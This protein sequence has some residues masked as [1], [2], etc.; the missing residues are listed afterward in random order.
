M[1]KNFLGVGWK[2]PVYFADNGFFDI[3]LNMGVIGL[4]LFFGIYIKLG[5]RSICQ[6][7]KSKLWF[8]FFPF[9]IF[10]YIF[11]GNLTYSFLLEVDQFVWMLM[12]I[13]VFVIQEVKREHA[14]A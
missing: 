1:K 12:I 13:G 2:Y 11:T 14:S 3:M 8:H 6:G 7:I 5:I 4:L 10:L 9:L